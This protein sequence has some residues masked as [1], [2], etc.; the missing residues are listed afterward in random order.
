MDRWLATLGVRMVTWYVQNMAATSQPAADRMHTRTA[1]QH[2]TLSHHIPLNS[3]SQDPTELCC[4]TSLPYPSPQLHACNCR[5]SEL[6]LWGG[7]D[8]WDDRVWWWGRRGGG[9]GWRVV[10]G[11]AGAES[12][13]AGMSCNAGAWASGCCCC[14]GRCNCDG[15]SPGQV[16]RATPTPTQHNSPHA[17][18]SLDHH[19][20]KMRFT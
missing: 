10:A 20:R 11:G 1:S 17:I 13:V 9:T 15:L 7:M 4:P 6:G 2:A 3:I 12:V 18:P 19:T 14:I 8:K 16:W 5:P